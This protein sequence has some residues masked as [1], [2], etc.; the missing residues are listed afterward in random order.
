MSNP[1]SCPAHPEGPIT[2]G[3]QLVDIVS[4]PGSI[5]NSDGGTGSNTS[6]SVSHSESPSPS[7]VASTS[8]PS[9]S[10][11]SNSGGFKLQNGKDAQALN[12]KFA[13]LSESSS[14]QTGDQACIR[15][16]DFAQCVG[17]KFVTTA[18]AASLGCFA[19][20]LVNSPGTSLACTT[21]VDAES[22]IAASGATGGLTGSNTSG[23]PSTPTTSNSPPSSVNNAA[24]PVTE[25]SATSVFTLQNG[26]DAQILNAKFA[27][28]TANSP[29]ESGDQACIGNGFAQCVNGSFV[30]SQCSATLVCVALPLVNSPGTSIACTTTTDAVARIAAT[31]ATGGITGS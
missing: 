24:T 10:S 2:D 22:R 3:S 11:T 21:Q 13:F 9:T 15:G 19:L 25:I 1:G 27:T 8:S 12:A 17:G 18:C 26:K 30:V 28:L 5:G 31:G 29:C 7:T 4:S 16:T 6:I 14:C 20:P 23:A